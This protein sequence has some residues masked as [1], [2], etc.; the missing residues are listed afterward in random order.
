MTKSIDVKLLFRLLIKRWYMFIVIAAVSLLSA[1]LITRDVQPDM[2]VARTS[3]SSIV[4]GSTQD[5][6]NG[7][8]LLLNY[9]SLIGSGKIAA[10]AAD[11]LPEEL[12]LNASRIQ[13]MVSANFNTES[14]F[15][16]VQASDRNPQI[17]LSVSNAVADAFVAEISNITGDDTIKIYDRATSAVKIYDGLSTQRQTRVMAPVASMFVL[18]VAIV[19]WALFSDKVKSV[20]EI[21]RD[22]EIAIFGVIPPQKKRMVKKTSSS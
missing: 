18:L 19:L 20:G 12:G 11:M 15:L 16:Y 9:S 6:L 2:Y 1:V 3:I 13:G 17:T 7:F 21:E 10:K 22:C 4:E 14:S 8:K 5:S